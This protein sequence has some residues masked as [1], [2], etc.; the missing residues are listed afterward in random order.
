MSSTPE[1]AKLPGSDP[2]KALPLPATPKPMTGRQPYVAF[3]SS[4][5]SKSKSTLITRSTLYLVHRNHSSSTRLRSSMMER[6]AAGM[7]VPG[8]K[9]SVTPALYSAS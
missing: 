4:A 3:V 7:R 9:T 2:M 8:P 1:S 6:A 5:S